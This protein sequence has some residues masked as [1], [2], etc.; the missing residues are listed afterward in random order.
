MGQETTS[1]SNAFDLD[2]LEK[3]LGINKTPSAS[4]SS[5]VTNKDVFDFLSSLEG[6]TGS[7]TQA[8]SSSTNVSSGSGGGGQQIDIMSTMNAISNPA[9]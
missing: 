2:A 1:D 6:S 8:F 5:S 3:S 9:K 4:Q 7:N